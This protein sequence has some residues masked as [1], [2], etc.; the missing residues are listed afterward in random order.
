[1][2]IPEKF[3]KTSNKFEKYFKEIV[4]KFQNFQDSSKL[5]KKKKLEKFYLQPT[6]GK[7]E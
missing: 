3:E 2:E 1:M 4:T 5:F 7:F 6:V